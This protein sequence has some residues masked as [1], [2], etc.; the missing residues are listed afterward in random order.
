MLILSLFKIVFT[1]FRRGL[2][3]S[4]FLLTSSFYNILDYKKEP[5]AQSST[6]EVPVSE[7]VINHSPHYIIGVS[8]Y[9][10]I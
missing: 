2:V 6:T 4:N 3:C 10:D 8:V 1:L 7:L 5:I 9:S